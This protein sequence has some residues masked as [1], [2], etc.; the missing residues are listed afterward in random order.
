MTHK[1]GVST[2]TGFEVAVLYYPE[3][4]VWHSA[5]WMDGGVGDMLTTYTGIQGICID[6]TDKTFTIEVVNGTSESVSKE[7]RAVVEKSYGGT[8]GKLYHYYTWK[9]GEKL[10]ISRPHCTVTMAGRSHK[11]CKIL[12]V[13]DPVTKQ[14]DRLPVSANFD[15]EQCIR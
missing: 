14:W 11:K 6:R 7:L 10:V 15:F 13:Y 1:V 9:T 3:K 8:M 2:G 5:R 12:A 4:N